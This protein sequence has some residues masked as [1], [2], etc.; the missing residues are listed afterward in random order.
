M[1][2]MQS[3]E[4][5]PPNPV[6]G[7]F[8]AVRKGVCSLMAVLMIVTP[9]WSFG[10]ETNMSAIGKEAHG[11]SES[12]GSNALSNFSASDGTTLKYQANGQTGSI[13]SNDLSAEAADLNR[14]WT[15]EDINALKGLFDGDDGEGTERGEAAREELFGDDQT[16]EGQ[17]HNYLVDEA[18]RVDMDKNDQILKVAENILSSIEDITDGFADCSSDTVFK[19]IMNTVHVPKLVQCEQVLDR[20][21]PCTIVHDYQAG[22]IRYLDGPYNIQS[23]GEGC[24]EIWLGKVG[25]N[26]IPGGSCSLHEEEILFS[27]VNPDAITV[28]ELDYAAFDD[29]MQV[30]IGPRGRETKVYQGPKDT[31]PY[32]EH[33]SN[34]VPGV[35]C[36]LNTHWIW[37]PKGDGYKC[38]EDSCA[39]IQQSLPAVDIT[40]YL[41]SAGENGDVRFY[42]RDAIGG[43]GEAF[44]R[45]RIYYDA[46]KAIVDDSWNPG[47]CLQ[48][49]TGVSDGFAKGSVRCIDMPQIDSA[50]GCAVIDGVYV[51]EHHLNPSPLSKLGIS[52]LCRKVAVE[53]EFDYYKGD[54]EWTGPNGETSTET[55]AG[56]DLDKCEK[57]VEQGCTFM[58]SECTEGAKGESGTCYIAD[59]TYDCGEDVPVKDTE[60]STEY[61]CPGEASCM[62]EECINLVRDPDNES[63]AQVSALLNSLQY[64]G[65]DMECEGTDSSGAVTGTQNV[66]CK[67]FSGNPSKCKIIVGGVQDCCEPAKP[68][69][70]SPYLNMLDMKSMGQAM[71]T[72]SN[73]MANWA[74]ENISQEVADMVN[75]MGHGAWSFT[76]GASWGFEAAGYISYYS[77]FLENI[78]SWKDLFLPSM[79]VLMKHAVTAI[80][81]YIRDAL[82]QLF[83]EAAKQLVGEVVG[84]GGGGGA[85]ANMPAAAGEA[86]ATVGAALGVVAMIYAAY[87]AAVMLLQA[88]YKCT[89]E[90][91]QFT[92]MLDV[93]NCHYIGS[94]CDSKVLGICI[95]KIRSYC[96]FNSPLS[97]ILQE[98]IR[99]QGDAIG[100]EFGSFGS[101]KNPQCAGVPLDKVGLIDWDKVDLSEWIAILQNNGKFPN[102]DNVNIETLTGTESKLN[103]DGNRVDT[104]ER[105]TARFKAMQS[106]FGETPVDERRDDAAEAFGIDSGYRPDTQ[107]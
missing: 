104:I 60:I 64:M 12:L 102:A 21:G 36:E 3:W 101:A 11:L 27:V 80:K 105:N 95:K 65:Q 66:T 61:D 24:T 94:Y 75:E 57:Y 106:Q 46:S 53:A 68:V 40:S 63:F 78:N 39:Y 56:G 92:A 55:G 67:V 38:T 33:S 32:E 50:T 89:D 58:R 17:I 49:A 90:E 29:Q 35:A 96:C 73:S 103:Y 87:C 31:F 77:T 59:V 25:N 45:M 79:D 8:D 98:Q 85:A 52:N 72:A 10:S 42:L 71:L 28:A 88:I 7:F 99:K 15:W 100:V 107:K 34:R 20:S 37:D 1:D 18:N 41:K 70:M 83:K 54:V 51:C 82:T 44:A 43:H 81:L 14:K 23:C 84:G 16:I 76:Q 26:Y 91:L 13:N 62:G 48:A 9:T 19:D 4:R 6:R 74:E 86:M 47:T 22:V 97:R 2:I 30:W 5:I 93:G 69:G